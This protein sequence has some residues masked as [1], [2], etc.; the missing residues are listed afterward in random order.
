MMNM[1]K[2]GSSYVAN[3]FK[4]RGATPGEATRMADMKKSSTAAAAKKRALSAMLRK[5]GETDAEYSA[6]KKAGSFGNPRE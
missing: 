5:K 2:S 4:E 6:R 3:K 1:K